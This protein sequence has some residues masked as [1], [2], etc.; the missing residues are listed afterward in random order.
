MNAEAILLK[1]D[2]DARNAAAQTLEDAKRRS[3]ELA[4]ASQ[5]RMDKARAASVASAEVEA[6]ALAGRMRRMAELEDRKHILARKRELIAEA[7]ASAREKLRGMEPA[8]LRDFLLRLAMDS[9]EGGET[10]FVGE[11]APEWCDA[12]FVDAL[13]A[14]LAEKGRAP[15]RV[16]E[17]RRAGVTGLAL[18]REGME[19]N[20]TIEAMLDAVRLDMESEIAGILFPENDT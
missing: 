8:A 16:A 18:A 19:M 12:G 6:D 2:E 7:F 3:E 10:L 9:A 11:I 15:V 17:E 5:A 1:I 13:N 4:A 14:A 20:L